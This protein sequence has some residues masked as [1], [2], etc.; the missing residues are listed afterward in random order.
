MIL[1]PQKRQLFPQ[2]SLQHKFPALFKNNHLFFV[3]RYYL[4]YFHKAAGVTIDFK[5]SLI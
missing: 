3:V 5:M 2:E 1:G 4:Y